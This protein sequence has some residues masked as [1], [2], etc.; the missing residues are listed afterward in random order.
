MA[1]SLDKRIERDS[2]LLAELPLCQLR[3]QNDQRY[4]WL[5]LV[6]KIDNVTEV[7]DLNEQ[8][9]IQLIKESSSV[10]R[11]LKDLTDCKKVNVANLGNVCEQLHWHIVARNEADLTWPG[12]IWG[13]G[14]AIPWDEKKRLEF[15]QSLLELLQPSG[16]LT[17]LQAY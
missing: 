11:V 6:P 14:N 10:S 16:L 5:V 8:Q 2:F 1:F 3:L 17:P 9:V 7:H 13:V 15:S 4:P 12:P